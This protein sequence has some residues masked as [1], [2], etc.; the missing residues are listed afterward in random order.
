MLSVLLANA[1]T[2]VRVPAA[3]QLDQQQV[4]KDGVGSDDE[5]T[6]SGG[7]SDD[8][9]EPERAVSG[10][11][12]GFGLATAMFGKVAGGVRGVGGGMK[13]GMGRVMRRPKRK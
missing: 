1:H 10:S 13:A 8:S 11:K 5:F 9:D 2:A 12:R 3:R 6:A 4:V 7:D